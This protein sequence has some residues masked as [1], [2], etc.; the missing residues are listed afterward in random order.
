MIRP[1]SV[2]S[3]PVQG[4]PV[5]PWPW[6]WPSVALAG[7]GASRSEPSPSSGS[8]AATSRSQTSSSAA[9]PAAVD[10]LPA[11]EYPRAGQFPPVR[12]RSLRQLV[13]SA[14]QFG[15]ATGTFTPGTR[16]LAFAITA[17]SGEFIYA[18][19]AVYISR[20]PTGPAQGPF[21]AP[22]DPMTVA[23]PYR[24]R[25]NSGPGGIRAIYAAELP[26]PR[27]GTYTVLSVTR[28]PRGLIGAP[29]EI[30][31]ASSSPIPD[32]VFGTTE[33]ASA[34]KAALR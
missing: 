9:A 6:P 21:L 5:G 25:E 13:D 26:V 16:R 27:A 20:G 29:G 11:A 3:A 12:G 15:A 33:L 7:C 2:R 30:A 4:S 14:A 23:P 19:T 24:S 34:L 22:A 18:P 1:M 10:E 17:S 32:V 31:V 8:A 28:T